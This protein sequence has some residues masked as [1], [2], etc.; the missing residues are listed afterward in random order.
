MARKEPKFNIARDGLGWGVIDASDIF[1]N[2]EPFKTRQEAVD[3]RTA[4]MTAYYNERS[5]EAYWAQSCFG[6]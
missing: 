5:N 2:Q 3:F 4:L 6:E 1:E